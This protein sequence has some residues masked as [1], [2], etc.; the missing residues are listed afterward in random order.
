MHYREDQQRSD[1]RSDDDVKRREEVPEDYLSNTLGGRLGG[2][3]GKT[4]RVLRRRFSGRQSCDRRP[5][6]DGGYRCDDLVPLL[7]ECQDKDR[8]SEALTVRA[9]P[10]H[11][12]PALIADN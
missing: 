12:Q 2:F 11:D 6:I 3:V 1:D 7:N 5:T 8:G 4:S 10:V 9:T